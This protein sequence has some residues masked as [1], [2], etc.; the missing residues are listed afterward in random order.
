MTREA[1]DQRNTPRKPWLA[2]LLAIVSGPVAFAYVGRLAAGLLLA[3]ASFGILLVAGRTGA[4]QSPGGY[5]ST[6]AVLLAI[7]VVSIVVP[8]LGARSQR[9]FF[10]PRWYNRWYCYVALGL[11]AS[12]MS[13]YALAN[14]E[15][16]FEFSTY[17]VPSGSMEPT[18]NNGDFI[19]VDARP[20][21]L[22][23]L[24]DGDLVVHESVA[25]SGEMRV[26]RIVAG[27]HQ[28]VVI[29]NEGLAV[30]GVLKPREN[31]KGVDVLGDKWMQFV[32]VTLDD[33]EYYV[34]G[35]NRGNSI[36]SRT[37]GPVDRSDLRGLV[38]TIWYSKDLSRVGPINRGVLSDVAQGP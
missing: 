37:E 12:L 9:Q 16:L 3:L 19:L 18:I 20:G 13:G 25:R 21:V 2:L 8:W 1:R 7:L 28:R 27:P 23:T 14:R 10:A 35:D 34:M 17:R 6:L 24:R 22:A 26:R 5:F 38:T 30:D 4:L 32:D 31:T 33:D 15:R 29:T 11:S 36:D